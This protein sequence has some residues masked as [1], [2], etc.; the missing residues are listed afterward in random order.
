MKSLIL[1]VLVLFIITPFRVRGGGNAEDRFIPIV[2]ETACDTVVESYVK[3]VLQEKRCIVKVTQ[4]FLPFHFY[5]AYEI[6]QAATLMVNE[7]ERDQ[8][9]AFIEDTYSGP[10]NIETRM[11]LYEAF[12][13]PKRITRTTLPKLN[14][15]WEPVPTPHTI[16]DIVGDNYRIEFPD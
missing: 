10:D 8:I 16:A 2:V 13:K 15:K 6:L 4:D 12:S 5:C 1:C 7:D 11:D 14:L 3:L 9:R